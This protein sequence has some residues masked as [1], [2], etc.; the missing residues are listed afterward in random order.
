MFKTKENQKV[1]RSIDANLENQTRTFSYAEYVAKVKY[2]TTRE[3]N[4]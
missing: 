1:S 4:R 3:K 2:S